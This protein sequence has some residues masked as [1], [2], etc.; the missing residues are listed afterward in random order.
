M[1]K[2]VLEKIGLKYDDLSKVELETFHSWEEALVK[3]QVTVES[4]RKYIKAMRDSVEQ[5]LTVSNIK[6]KQDIFLK[7]R[8]RNYMLIEAYL[9]TPEKAKEAL[10]RAVA[11]LVS[12]RK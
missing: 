8:L 4:I 1:I 2:E 9:S 12:K 7:A 11:G 10:D 6:T 3:S 5:E